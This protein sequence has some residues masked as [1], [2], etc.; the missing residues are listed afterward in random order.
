[1]S[2][3]DDELGR[4]LFACQ[5]RSWGPSNS[6]ASGLESG[7]GRSRCFFT[8]DIY[9]RLKKKLRKTNFKIVSISGREE[10]NFG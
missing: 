4:E 9:G 5:T 10:R 3:N 7:G 2:K 8:C 1:M 6:R